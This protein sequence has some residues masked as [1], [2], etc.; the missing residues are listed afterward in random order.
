LKSED[1]ML[2]VRVFI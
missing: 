2:P 1:K